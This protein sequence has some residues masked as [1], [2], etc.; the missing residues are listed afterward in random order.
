MNI[1]DN[2]Y[3]STGQF[4]NAVRNIKTN[5]RYIG[6]DSE[7]NAVYDRLKKLPVI[8]FTGTVKLHGTNASIVFHEDSVVSFHSKSRMLGYIDA[9]GQFTL[10]SDN[11]E[12]AQSMFRRRDALSVLLEE[13]KKV[14][15]AQYGEVKYPIKLS[16][17]WVGQGIQKGVGCSLINKRSLVIFG[18]KCGETSQKQ[19]QGW[20]PV[21][22]TANLKAPEH[23]IFT[24]M[25]YSP[26][27]IDINFNGEDYTNELIGHV[28]RVENEC[29]F[30]K[31]MGVTDNLIGE[32]LVFTP[33]DPDYAW[34]TGTWFKVKG[35][36]HSV[37]KVKTLVATCPEKLKGIKAFV[38]YAV[39]EN[40]LEQGVSEVG[41]DQSLIGKFI[42]WVN[43]DINKEEGDVLESNNLSMKEVGKSCSN[44]AREYYINLLDKESYERTQ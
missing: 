30:A 28:M 23:N 35:K 25:D 33:N 22:H 4:R 11:S 8:T 42:G 7:G 36:K 21:S 10:N 2:K 3:H 14:S 29:P 26:V 44:K 12:F 24:V 15:I 43:K 27:E 20:L 17:E 1:S 31:A 37:S 34:D 39:T 9:H 41:L 6:Q 32:G 40:R 13:A 19:K 38:E 18:I 16:G 5:A